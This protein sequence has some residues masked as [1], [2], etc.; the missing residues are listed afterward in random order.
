LRK[1]RFRVSSEWSTI[2]EVMNENQLAGK[3]R[4]SA[5]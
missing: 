4:G 3:G 2:G 1:F 5:S